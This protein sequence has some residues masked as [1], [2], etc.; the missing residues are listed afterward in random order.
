[1]NLPLKGLLQI[2]IVILRGYRLRLVHMPVNIISM[3]P[4]K[5]AIASNAGA[6]VIQSIDSKKLM[7]VINLFNKML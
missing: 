1:L 5:M 4:T 7:T 3:P 6:A 2:D